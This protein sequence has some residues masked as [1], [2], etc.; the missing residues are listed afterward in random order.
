MTAVP[1]GATGQ[2]ILSGPSAEDVNLVYDQPMKI[3]AQIPKTTLKIEFIPLKKADAAAVATTLSQ[4]YT[5][6]IVQP[7]NTTLN[8]Q[9]KV[10]QQT[11]QGVITQEQLS[12]V[13]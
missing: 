10:Q 2:I 12:S 5:R 7:A 13:G 4:L 9:G 11:N 3:L 8:S 6:V 1:V